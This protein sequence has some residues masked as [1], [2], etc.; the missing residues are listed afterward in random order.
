MT[1]TP[2]AHPVDTYLAALPSPQQETL[3]ALRATI[4]SI[5]PHADEAISYGMPAFTLGGNP[6][7]GY[8]SFKDHC[9]YFPMSGS[10]LDQAGDLATKYAVSKGG[11]QFEIDKRLPVGVIR[12]LLKLRIAELGAVDMGRRNEYYDDGQLKAT[13]NMKDGKL[14]GKWEWYR[15]DGTLMRTGAFKDGEQSGTW[16]TWNRDGSEGKSTLF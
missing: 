13:G 5:L 3:T 1:E 8:A 15:S 7:A 2:D 12:R 9:T 11:I 4:R 14:H 6:V 10:V 16:T